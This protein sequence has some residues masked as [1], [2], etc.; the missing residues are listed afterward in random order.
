[1][2]F[3]QG[4]SPVRFSKQF[5]PLMG[6]S[7]CHM[8]VYKRTGEIQPFDL[9]KI[10]TTIANA[11]DEIGQPMTQGDI[12]YVSNYIQRLLVTQNEE[13]IRYCK[14]HQAVINGLKKC[15]FPDI[16]QAYDQSG[17]S[18]VKK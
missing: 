12:D 10:K 16:A 8:K 6:R 9:Q 5:D 17:K 3:G 4:F 11:S 14:V 15:G 7:H 13:I 1:M 18:H 2:S